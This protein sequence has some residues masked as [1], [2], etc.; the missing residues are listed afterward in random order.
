MTAARTREYLVVLAGVAFCALLVAGRTISEARAEL[1]V[2]R[3][4]E[5]AG[6]PLRAVEHYRRALRWSFPLSPYAAE[7]VSDLERIAGG[8]EAAGDVDGALLAW[9]SLAGGLGASRFLYSGA[10]PSR[11]HAKDEIA[12]LL[13]EHGAA[14]TDARLTPARLAAD[15][16]RL[17]EREARADPFWGTVL[18]VG[19]LIWVLS[20]IS[21]TRRGFDSNGELRWRDAKWP[22]SGALVGIVFL[23]IGLLFA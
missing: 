18:L 4:H 6:A 16:R 17:L 9:R 23:V 19:F 2:A 10:D 12:R 15:H 22:A 7:A 13:G 8:L 1:E 5:G 21:M 3:E 14:P 20:L 11:E